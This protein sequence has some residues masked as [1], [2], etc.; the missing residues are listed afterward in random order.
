MADRMHSPAYAALRASS[1]R[2]LLF[3]EG[4]LARAGGGSVTLYADQLAVVGSVRIV[5]PGLRELHALGFLEVQRHP[6]RH[7]C[8][9]SDRWRAVQ[10]AK[11][12]ASI[13][14][15]A[16]DQRMPPQPMPSQ[17]SATSANAQA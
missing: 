16:R 15:R 11:Q 13:S 6:K 2:L 12:A 5:L 8:A 9:L 17:P 1:R 4:E 14:A 3:V 10:T 7:A